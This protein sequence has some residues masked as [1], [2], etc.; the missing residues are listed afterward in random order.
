MDRSDLRAGQVGARIVRLDG[1]VIPGRDLALEDLGRRLGT[2][3]EVVDPVQVVD[4]RDRGDVVRDLNQLARRTPRSRLRQLCGV[5]GRVAA[6]EGRLATGDEL[7]AA[8]T[9]P[10]RVVRDRRAGVLVLELRGPGL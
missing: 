3:L 1:G 4:D 2:E 8:A 10:D 5:E 6:G 9:R 7:V